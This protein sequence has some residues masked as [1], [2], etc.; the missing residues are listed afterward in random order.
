MIKCK[1]CDTECKNISGLSRHNKLA[2]NIDLAQFKIKYSKL[3][4][5]K[6]ITDDMIQCDAALG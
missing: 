4:P 1:Y 2:H 5:K 6:E 3:F